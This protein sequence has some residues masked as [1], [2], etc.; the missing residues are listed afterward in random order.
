[1]VASGEFFQKNGNSNE[2]WLTSLYRQV[3]V[4]EPDSTGYNL[5][6][7][8]LLAGYTAARNAV[9]TAIT[10]SPEYRRKV[11]ADAYSQLLKRPAAAAEIDAWFGAMQ[12]GASDETVIANILASTEYFRLAGNTTSGW[13][14]KLLHDLVG[15]DPERYRPLF[16]SILGGN[17]NR[18]QA[19]TALLATKEYQ[20][21]LIGTFYLVYLGRSPAAV[22][23]DAWVG[24]F[25]HGASDEQITAAIVASAEYFLRARRLP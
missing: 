13:L 23:A 18:L 14:E 19:A 4:R 20:Q 15:R 6:L 24:A 5:Q 11:I 22:E 25:A 10:T 8:G 17:A 7:T 2:D 12:H 3:L 9:S 1:V 21:Y 16:Q